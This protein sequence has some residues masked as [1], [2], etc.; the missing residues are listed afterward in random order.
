MAFYEKVGDFPADAPDVP[1]DSLVES[2]RWAGLLD[3]VQTSAIL[4]VEDHFA[5]FEFPRVSGEKPVF[6]KL[7]LPSV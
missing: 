2:A 4:D 3:A 5:A 6:G 1:A 7:L